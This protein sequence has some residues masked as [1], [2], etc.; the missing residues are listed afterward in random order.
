ME[1]PIRLEGRQM[2]TYRAIADVAE[3][4]REDLGEDCCAY[5]DKELATALKRKGPIK[6]YVD[7]GAKGR[8]GHVGL[9]SR[10]SER[11]ILKWDKEYA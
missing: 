9:S 7:P 4:M 2:G 8:A 5:S 10:V 11:A 6:Y 3:A 1:K